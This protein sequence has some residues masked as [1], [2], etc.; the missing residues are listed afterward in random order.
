MNKNIVKLLGILLAT[1]LFGGNLFAQPGYNPDKR[2]IIGLN[3]ECLPNTIVTAVPFLRIGP[4]ARSGGMGDA[5][6]AISADA[7]SMHFNPS[8]LAF[9]EEN[10]GVGVNYT[11]WLSAIVNDVFLA[12]LSGYKKLDD[13][14]A[15]GGSLRYFSLGSIPFTTADGQSLGDGSPNEF[16]L[17]VGY[18][19]KLSDKLSVSLAAKYIYSNLA[20]GQ[21]VSGVEIFAGNAGAADIGVTYK[22]ALNTNSDSELT[23]AGAITN[24]GSKIS[25]TKDKTKDFIPTNLGIGAAYKMEIDDYNSITIT[26]DVNKLLVPTPCITDDCDKVEGE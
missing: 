7:N 22:T 6:L 14:Q 16:E 9:A 10:V 13:L 17:A 20:A 25:Y 3:G 19:R 12:Y 4:D 8:K 24:I 5:G 26:G 15:I 18:A 1:L 11:P 21:Q 23:I 2:C